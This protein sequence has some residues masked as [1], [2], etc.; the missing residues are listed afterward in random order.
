MFPQKMQRQF[1]IMMLVLCLGFALGSAPAYAGGGN[2][3]PPTANPHGYSL[4][5]MAIALANFTASGNDLTYYPNTPF[6]ILY[7]DFSKPDGS[8]TF[9][10]RPGTEF[11]VPILQVNDSP[12][13]YGDFPTTAKQ[14]ATYIFS[15]KQIGGQDFTITVDRR[16]TT[17]GRTYVAGPVSVK[18]LLGGGSHVVQLGAFLTPLTKGTHTVA[19]SG[20]LNGDALG[21]PN[22]TFAFT[23]TV[24]VQ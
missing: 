16:V 15:Q 20:R 21:N 14:A 18:D 9:E 12:P 6:Q 17:I 24:I 5:K 23:Y 7:A 13:V 1:L 4:E 11:F 2:V 3:L 22:I 10:V 19:I 8:N